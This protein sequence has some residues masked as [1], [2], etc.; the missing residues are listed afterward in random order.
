[1]ALALDMITG[2]LNSMRRASQIV[3]L[4]PESFSLLEKKTNMSTQG[5][6]PGDTAAICAAMREYRIEA[7]EGKTPATHP[8]SFLDLLEEVPSLAEAVKR[9]HKRWDKE[10]AGDK[11]NKRMKR[12]PN[13]IE[14]F[15]DFIDHYNQG[16]PAKKQQRPRNPDPNGQP[17]PRAKAATAMTQLRRLC[18]KFAPITPEAVNAALKTVLGGNCAACLAPVTRANR[19]RCTKPA[20]ATDPAHASFVAKIT[21]AATPAAL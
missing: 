1:M 20:C 4:L 10:V 3:S 13:H 21:A 9:V 19:M 11:K 18:T 12:G 5:R 16:N 8:A 2:W 15:N 7:D 17:P 6:D 14:D